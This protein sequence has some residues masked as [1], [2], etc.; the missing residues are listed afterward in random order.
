MLFM[1]EH[2]DSGVFQLAGDFADTK[3]INAF[4]TILIQTSPFQNLWK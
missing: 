1:K 2:I 4:V 3:V